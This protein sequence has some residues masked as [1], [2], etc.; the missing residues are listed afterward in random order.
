MRYLLIGILIFFV[1]CD[2]V[3]NKSGETS[4]S[5]ENKEITIYCENALVPVLMELKEKFESGNDC[6]IK[7]HNDCA[8]N[9]SS[10]IQYTNEGDIYIPASSA[11]FNKLK[12]TKNNIPYIIDSVFVGYNTLVVMSLKDNPS[13]YN[14]DLKKLTTKE[15][16]VI[17][18]NPESSSLGYETRK[19]LTQK[20]LYDDMILN[21]VALSTDSRGLVKS[22][23]NEEAQL[24]INWESDIHNNGNKNHV[25]IFP[26]EDFNEN[27]SEIYAGILSTSE[28]PDLAKEFLT[29]ATGEEGISVF[30][31]YGFNRRKTLIF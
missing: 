18:G 9:L 12:N 26:I 6:S 17:I 27:P 24:V 2:Q 3:K 15:Y 5:N 13:G 10:L 7:L 22:L 1:A 23:V 20:D 28:H 19:I 11:G 31:K 30:R 4:Q 21:V 29:Y 8:Q 25:E 16:A 14:G